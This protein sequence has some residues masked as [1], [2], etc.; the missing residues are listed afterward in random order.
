MRRTAIKVGS[1]TRRGGLVELLPRWTVAFSCKYLSA[2]AISPANLRRTF[3]SSS[4]VW[5]RRRVLSAPSMSSV[6]RNARESRSTPAPVSPKLSCQTRGICK[7]TTRQCCRV[8]V[9]SI[10]VKG[11]QVRVPDR[12]HEF[13]LYCH[14]ETRSACVTEDARKGAVCREGAFL[15]KVCTHLSIKIL[16][17]LRIKIIQRVFQNFDCYWNVPDAV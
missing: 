4:I 3:Q 5:S 16:E 13:D 1:G 8:A 6:T 11:Q 14:S 10:T 9:A 7:I 15:L 12:A 2:R 17:H